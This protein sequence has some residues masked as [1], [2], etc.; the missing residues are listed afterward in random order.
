MD[1]REREREVTNWK[2]S[3]SKIVDDDGYFLEHF[4]DDGSIGGKIF[5]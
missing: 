5:F 1:L 2:L 3:C 4:K